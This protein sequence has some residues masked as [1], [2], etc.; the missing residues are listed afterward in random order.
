MGV[1]PVVVAD[2]VV[3]VVDHVAVMVVDHV[4]VMVVDHVAVMVVD[5]VAIVVLDD[6][7]V[8]AMRVIAGR[9]RRHRRCGE[10]GDGQGT[11]GQQGKTPC[12][13]SALV[14]LDR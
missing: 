5:H 14:S 1:V 10:R 2:L 13:G 7:A 6:L 9:G 3:M 11:R 4:A 12:R 8:V